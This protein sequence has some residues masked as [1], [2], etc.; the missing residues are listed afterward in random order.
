VVRAVFAAPVHSA[1]EGLLPAVLGSCMRLYV[2]VR[3]IGG[4]GARGHVHI[5]DSV[6]VTDITQLGLR[7]S[8]VMWRCR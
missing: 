7:S 4:A 3:G 5:A 8:D 2:A 6:A 1:I